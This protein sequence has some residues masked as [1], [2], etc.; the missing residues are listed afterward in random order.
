[1]FI[2]LRKAFQKA[3]W[4]I[5]TD[6]SD[7]LLIVISARNEEN[8]LPEAIDSLSG[9][10]S[11]F[12]V[13]IVDDYSTDNTYNAGNDLSISN[14]K[15]KIIRNR[16]CQG[17]KYSLAAGIESSE[18]EYIL[19]TDS[20]CLSEKKW[21]SAYQRKFQQGYDLLFGIAPFIVNRKLVT[22]ISAYENLR[23]F[24]LSI[25]ASEL[26]M[27]YSAA[28]R[29]LGFSR[30]AFEKIGGYKNTLDVPFGDDGLL[31]R[32]AVK[33]KL[34][35]GAVTEEGSKVFSIPKQN[36]KEYFEQRKRHTRTSFYY[37]PKVKLSLS[38]WH[39]FN[40]IPIILLFLIHLNIYF[41]VP[42]V[43]KILTDT[44][45]V[46]FFQK[47]FGYSFSIPHIIFLQIIYEF[48][49]IINFLNAL[50]GKIKWK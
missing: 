35:I 48:F 12:T 28:A 37:S 21:V 30:T 31:I 24:M 8:N 5:Y 50:T 33:H 41:A 26:K 10:D 36:F 38:I 9:Q 13:T 14:P 23:A 49:I 47:K 39:L 25:S 46:L 16:Y 19:I 17:K 34:K 3:I 2:G 22:K 32:E 20:D 43:V 40:I 4:P 44:G 45:G 29:S 42:F 6:S 11:D 7:K 27:P 18:E 15:I 1:L